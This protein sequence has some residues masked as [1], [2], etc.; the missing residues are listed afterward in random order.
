[1]FPKIITKRGIITDPEGQTTPGKVPIASSDKQLN[2]HVFLIENLGM[3][4]ANLEARN[5]SHVR[6]GESM[7]YSKNLSNVLIK[8]YS[9]NPMTVHRAPVQVRVTYEIL[10]DGK[11]LKKIVKELK[12]LNRRYRSALPGWKTKQDVHLKIRE[13]RWNSLKRFFSK[14]GEL[15]YCFKYKGDERATEGNFLFNLQ[16][17]STSQH[18]LIC[19]DF[20]KALADAQAPHG[21]IR[22]RREADKPTQQRNGWIK[23]NAQYYRKRGWRPREIVG[24]LQKELRNGTWNERSK[25]QFNI[26][27]ATICKIAGLKIT[28]PT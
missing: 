2:A 26:A 19:V 10:N 28:T 24:E 22:G 15:I 6:S 25:L 11:P 12:Q 27:T 16:I 3:F 4:L 18:Q 5:Y 1:M 17:A 13:R 7:V 21:L 20:I 8:N 23:R 14:H 9:Y